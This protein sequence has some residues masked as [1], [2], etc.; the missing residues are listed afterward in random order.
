MAGTMSKALVH[1]R[2]AQNGLY[3]ALLARRGFTASEEALEGGRGFLK[4]VGRASDPEAVVR[5]LGGRYELA[6]NTYKPYACGVVAHAV[7]DGCLA[8]RERHAVRPED[9]AHVSLAVHPQALELAGN[10]TFASALESK[11]SIYHSAAVALARGAAGEHEYDA[12]AVFD[13]VVS[14][15]RERVD[16]TADKTLAQEAARVTVTLTDGR[17]LDHRVEHA[18]GSIDNPMTDAQL[19]AKFRGLAESALPLERA[20]RALALCWRLETLEDV[21]E[22]VR[23]AVPA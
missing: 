8:L 11:W 7:I 18:S 21:A 20:E 3:A 9:V 5:G 6:L 2:A 17:T 14:E 16:A 23:A 19:S 15:L 1:G 4:V 22:I 13:P 10:R 12:R